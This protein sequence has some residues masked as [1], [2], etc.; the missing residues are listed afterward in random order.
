MFEE[1]FVCCC[2]TQFVL[3]FSHSH[4]VIWLLHHS[5]LC[6]KLRN[7]HLGQ[8]S[9][10][11][12]LRKCS[13]ALICCLVTRR[14]KWYSTIIY[15]SRKKIYLYW[16]ILIFD[17]TVENNTSC[18]V[19]GAVWVAAVVS[20]CHTVNCVWFRPAED[21][22]LRL[23]GQKCYALLVYAFTCTCFPGGPNQETF[24]MFCLFLVWF[25][26]HLATCAA[27]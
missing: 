21:W 17:V 1:P 12:A 24:N 22:W 9:L 3:L 20:K 25:C 5:C 15:C 18:H 27:H 13:N 23:G 4:Q 7:L 8:E 11:W 10:L 26:P 6:K 2:L 16:A 14:Q 19:Y